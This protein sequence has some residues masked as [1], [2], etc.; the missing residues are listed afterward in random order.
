MVWDLA[1]DIPE[2]IKDLR[3]ALGM[4]QAELAVLFGVSSGQVS[5]W[6][7]GRQKPYKKNLRRIALEHGWPL[8][9]FRE[10]GPMPVDTVSFTP[11]S[12]TDLKRAKVARILRVIARASEGLSEASRLLADGATSD[13]ERVLQRVVR[14]EDYG[15]EA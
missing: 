4:T 6:E 7:R 1:S 3:G 5:S 8:E 9:I 10:G 14:T 2:R 13:A 12:P 15:E 11:S